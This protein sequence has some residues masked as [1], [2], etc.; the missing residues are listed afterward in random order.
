MLISANNVASFVCL[1][2]TCVGVV[3]DCLHGDTRRM[4]VVGHT[5]SYH[6]KHG[7][8]HYLQI[9]CMRSLNSSGVD[10]RRNAIQPIVYCVGG[11]CVYL[12]RSVDCISRSICSE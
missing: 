5:H 3:I 9:M 8:L 7:N 12:C 10:K 1:Y 2:R 6:G 11:M 4:L